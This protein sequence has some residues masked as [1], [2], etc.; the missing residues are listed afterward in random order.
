MSSIIYLYKLREKMHASLAF[1]LSNNVN[2][3]MT[4]CEKIE[5]CLKKSHLYHHGNDRTLHARVTITL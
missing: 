2:I 1:V 4:F 5:H 3:S